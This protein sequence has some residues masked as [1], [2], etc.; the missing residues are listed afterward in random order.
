VP[1]VGGGRGEVLVVEAAGLVQGL[2]VLVFHGGGVDLHDNPSYL[3][4]GC[5]LTGA[6]W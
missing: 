4:I 3:L 5:L 2:Q 1:V 6:I